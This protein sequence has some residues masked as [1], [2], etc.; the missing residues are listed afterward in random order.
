MLLVSRVVLVVTVTLASASSAFAQ[1]TKDTDCKGDRVCVNGTCSDPSTKPA[2]PAEPEASLPDLTTIRSH[3]EQRLASESQGALA[4]EAF[5]K[6]NG[7]EQEL[8]HFYVVE[9]QADIRFDRQG[10]K[11]GDAIGGYWNDFQVMPAQ[12][13]FMSGSWIHFDQGARVR[14]T[15]TCTGRRTEKG[16]R[17]QELEIRS[18]QKLAQGSVAPKPQPDGVASAAPYHNSETANS[19]DLAQLTASLE[20]G[21]EVVFVVR[22]GLDEVHYGGEIGSHEVLVSKTEIAFRT[23]GGAKIF[24]VTPDKLLALSNDCIDGYQ[25]ESCPATPQNESNA[26]E[27]PK[28]YHIRVM[29]ARINSKGKE[30]KQKVDFYHPAAGNANGVHCVGC[31]ASMDI[32]YALLQ[33]IKDSR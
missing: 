15:G 7:Y 22:K 26:A 32:L 17:L 1:C 21:E 28:T 30:E 23:K 6:T 18:Y 19:H 5:E 13:G 4:L 25:R 11:P 2:R 31:D 10:W 16:W 27:G 3:L 14:L 29:V 24:S 9:W 20:R 33:K 8:T 12:G